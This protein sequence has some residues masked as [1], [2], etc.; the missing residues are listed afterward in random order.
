M[1]SL[2]VRGELGK[3][4]IAMNSPITLSYQDLLARYPTEY[5]AAVAGGTAA[6]F[7]YPHASF[8]ALLLMF[9]LMIPSRADQLATIL[10][11]PVFAYITYFSISTIRN[12]RSPDPAVGFAIGLLS[13]WSILWS[14]TLMIFND[15]RK[16]FSRIERR[17][18]PMGT[19]KTAVIAANGTADGS[20]TTGAQSKS[21]LTAETG[22]SERQSRL[23][24]Q[25][26][27]CG[28]K[29]PVFAHKSGS[30]SWQRLPESL[31]ER[32]DWVSD[33]VSNFRGIGWNW[34]LSGLPPPPPW[35][36]E[37]LSLN[38]GTKPEKGDTDVG[39]TGNVRYHTTSAL[40][41]QKLLAFITCYLA[42]DI[43][44]VL[45]TQDPYF[46][47]VFDLPPPSYLPTLIATSST[48]LRTYRLTLILL[49]IY[50][51]LQVLFFLAPLFLVGLVGTARIGAR[52][53]PWM[54]PDAYGSYAPVFDKGLGGW[55]GGWWHQ[56]F[57]F[58]FDS[59]S[60]WVVAKLRWHQKSAKAKILR[61]LIA[62]TISGALHACG[63]YTTWPHT[64]PLRGPF[65]FFFL[66]TWG[67]LAQ[68]LVAKG[69][70]YVGITQRVPRW[71]RRLANFVYVHVWFY[72]TAPLLIDDIAKGGVWLFE[73]VPVSLVRALG[74]GGNGKGWW[75]WGRVYL[76]WW[77]GGRWWES[78]V[79]F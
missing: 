16:D 45:T 55:W 32:I 38:D 60:K 49:L 14:A 66:Q 61:L 56:T 4:A 58:A 33:L 10:R 13:A 25:R 57:R 50:A 40:L 65:L 67:I 52:A 51:S 29:H 63:S 62:F 54:Y 26:S 17:D 6:P 12:C 78:G 59:A 36:Q 71:V 53:E 30:F 22:A 24:T 3:N 31:T 42:L 8:G 20:A 73:P 34:R 68:I 75:R 5:E 70:R 18:H 64:Q 43:C 41:S 72:Y 79:A 9:Y 21:A 76:K 7:V 37:Q 15:A 77:R 35:V 28:L 2:P 48:L 74:F 46:W 27:N 44:K 39:P 47:G 23:G 19:D 69:L 1:G 11:Y